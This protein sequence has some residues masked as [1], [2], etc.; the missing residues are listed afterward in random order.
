MATLMQKGSAWLGGT[1]I[2]EREE[3][4]RHMYELCR[5]SMT[6][7]E[8]T[9]VYGL[10]RSSRDC[11]ATHASHWISSGESTGNAEGLSSAVRP[12]IRT[13]VHHVSQQKRNQVGLVAQ[14][15]AG[16]SMC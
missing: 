6:L 16:R 2:V 4:Q 13:E 10:T 12:R 11:W 1:N 8:K 3:D 14:L 7:A 15:R 5:K 9:I